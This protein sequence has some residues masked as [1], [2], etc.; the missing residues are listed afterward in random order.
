MSSPAAPEKPPR[1]FPPPCWT[2]EETLALID[3]YRDRWY[4]LRR[5][6]LRTPD[7][8]AVAAAVASRCPGA[9]PAKTSAQC[10]HK[11]EKLRQRYRTEK[12]R[13]LSLPGRFFSSWFFFDNMD[14]MENGSSP[15]V[16]SDPL[17]GTRADP[18]G[19]LRILSLGDRNLVESVFGTKNSV[20]IDRNSNPNSDLGQEGKD[21]G[22]GNPVTLGFRGKNFSHK[23][24]ANSGPNLGSRVL[25]GYSLNLDEGSDEDIG[26][27]TDFAA[28]F[29]VI[30]ALDRKLV[31]PPLLRP[32]KLGKIH[33]PNFASNHDGGE[34][35]YIK[36]PTDQDLVPPEFN[37][38]KVDGGQSN[39]RYSI[40]MG[41]RTKAFSNS[42]SNLESRVLN[43][44][45]PAA[46]GCGLG[47]NSGGKG[48]KRERDPIGEMVSSINQLGEGFMKM[49]R[50]KMEMAREIEKMRMEMEMKRNELILDSQRQIVD[51]F[52]A[53]LMENKNNNNKNKKK[54]KKAAGSSMVSPES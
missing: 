15:A 24:S 11:M 25:N 6:Y 12:Q 21:F 36:N 32:N 38:K 44:F 45:S 52:L 30:T 37:P 3:A 48:T 8:D 31:P 17:A 26:D 50:M 22:D 54:K 41:F 34:G 53:V 18:G 13:S 4:V 27:N 16:R 9:T 19:V 42:C 7:W 39:D 10:R 49:E 35:F 40:P 29:R 28:G 51:A 20:K 1:R 33:G 23:V 14:S 46:F 43:G 5:G 47:K 2:Q